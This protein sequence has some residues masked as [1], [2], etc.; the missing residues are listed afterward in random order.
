MFLLD[1]QNLNWFRIFVMNGR[2]VIVV[3][4]KYIILS[5]SVS[6]MEQIHHV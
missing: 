3:I 5:M 6:T 1:L 4:K 2:V